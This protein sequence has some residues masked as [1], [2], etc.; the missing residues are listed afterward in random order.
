M[1]IYA[2]MENISHDECLACE[3]GLSLY[4]EADGKKILFDTG[5]SEKFADNAEKMGV[6]LK[7]VDFAAISHGHYDHGGG[8]KKFIEINDHA[9]IY[10]SDKGF[11]QYYSGTDFNVS[12]PEGLEGNERFVL[13]SE[14]LK[15][16]ENI[17]L[18]NC[19]DRE[20]KY[21][22]DPYGLNKVVDGEFIP[23]DFLHEQ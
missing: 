5:A 2:L 20:A 11:N 23:D 4:I 22:A 21:Y 19:N 10:I 13:T 8:L 7:A 16:S 1:K 12:I 6:D 18:L 14:P 15:L 9:P 3:H 17:T